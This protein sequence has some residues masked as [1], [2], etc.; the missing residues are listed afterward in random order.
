MIWQNASTDEIKRAYKRAALRCHPD[1]NP[2][3]ENEV[4]SVAPAGANLRAKRA[5]STSMR[6]GLGARQPRHSDLTSCNW[7]VQAKFKA[8][9]EAYEVLVDTQRRAVYDARGKE[10]ALGGAPAGGGPSTLEELLMRQMGLQ[11]RG[12]GGLPRA[13][14]I[15]HALE[16][17][18]EELYTGAE[19]ALEVSPRACFCFCS[20]CSPLWWPVC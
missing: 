5:A 7:V 20:D 19:K 18:L 15:A 17:T 4:R 1:R 8:V 12:G 9:S 16:V 3:P 2:G 14:D 13:R 6:L 11:G 10:E